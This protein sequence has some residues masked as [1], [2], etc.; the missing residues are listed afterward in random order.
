[1]GSCLIATTKEDLGSTKRYSCL[2]GLLAQE[3]FNF[4]LTKQENYNELVISNR[5]FHY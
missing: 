4:V 3:L 5:L 2:T 1:M